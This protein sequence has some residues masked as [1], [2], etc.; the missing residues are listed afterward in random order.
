ML[1]R[2]SQEDVRQL[3]VNL[4]EGDTHDE[5]EHAILRLIRCL[6]CGRVRDLMQRRGLSYE[7]F[8]DEVDGSEWDELQP[9]L[10]FA[11]DRCLG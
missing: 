4:F 8:D 6:P 5:D 10:L 7:E 2:L 9:I 11:R 3:L 1:N